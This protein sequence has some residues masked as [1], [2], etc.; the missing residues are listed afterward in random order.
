MERVSM[1]SMM[2]ISTVRWGIIGCGDVAEHKSGPALYQTPYSQLV[3]VTRRDATKAADFARRH[4][5]KRWYTNV[6]GLLADQE[7]NAVYVASPHG[8]HLPHVQRAAEAGK[9]I[10]CEKPM[11]TGTLEAQ[12]M[13]DTCRAHGVSLTVAYYRRFWPIIRTIQQLLAEGAIG[14]VIQARVQL[15]DYFAGDPDRPWLISRAQAGGG[16]LANAGS[17][18]VDLVRFLLGE[19]IEVMADCSS[20]ASGFEVEDTA[21]LY[22]RMANGALVSLASTW[23]SLSPINEIDLIGTKG[24]I[25][26]SPLSQGRLILQ[27]GSREPEILQC[28]RAGVAHSELLE[29][30]I[31]RLLAGQP[32]PIP[33]EEAV[34]AWRIMEAAYRSSA[35]GLR[36][37]I[38]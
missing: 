13:V 17:H 20:I 22:M 25:L 3:A 26:A 18:W 10:L 15:A 30:L 5:A 16:A 23:Q 1:C 34:A 8:V 21:L 4:G 27:Q 7:I 6:D 31:P 35:E 33:G 32:S 9:A 28:S 11:G 14:Q 19:V 37:R 29:E 24:R 2:V 38:A 36:V 12:Q